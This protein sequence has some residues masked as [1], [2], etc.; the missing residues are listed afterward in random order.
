MLTSSRS[1]KHH[2]RAGVVL[3]VGTLLM[4]GILRFGPA[5]AGKVTEALLSG[6][7]S[8]AAL[9]ALFTIIVSGAMLAV[10][11]VGAWLSRAG[12]V[13]G[14]RPLRGFVFGLSLGLGG[15]LLAVAY[16]WLAGAV[17][18]GS[19]HPDPKLLLAGLGVVLLQVAAE[20]YYFRGWIQLVLAQAWGGPLAVMI[21][22]A[23]FALV[24]CLGEARSA[25]TL[26]NLLIGGIWFGLLALRGGGMASAVGAHVAWN[27]AE[28]LLLGLDP[29][30]GV[31]GFGAVIDLDLVG[32]ALW[33][34]S[35]E[36]LNAS[37]A[38]MMALIV[39]VAPLLITWRK[40][41]RSPALA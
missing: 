5:L 9:E 22:A 2:L 23:I 36:G 33:G 30:P 11:V 4:A 40:G 32:S 3:V 31:G 7:P 37:F 27:A 35:S 28:Q 10:A 38:M 12:S 1:G 13:L 17:V 21:T 8:D 41:Q 15:L 18:P 29:N 19:A 16:A 25:V 6:T 39:F 34:G 20:E 24:H 26:A 14:P